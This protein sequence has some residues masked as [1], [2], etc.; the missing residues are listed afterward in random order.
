MEPVALAVPEG[1][2]GTAGVVL[3]TKVG[4]AGITDGLDVTMGGETTGTVDA[5]SVGE[6]A[7]GVVG[8]TGTEVATSAGEVGTAVTGLVTVQGQLVIVMVVAWREEVLAFCKFEVI[9]GLFASQGHS[10]GAVV[11]RLP[12]SQRRLMMRARTK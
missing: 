11:S 7:T 2:T 10:E 5:T 9:A 12:Q 3:L 8:T 6:V 1:A 4:G